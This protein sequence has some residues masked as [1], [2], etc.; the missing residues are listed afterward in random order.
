MIDPRTVVVCGDNETALQ[1][2]ESLRST[3]TGR[4]ILVPT[5]NYGAFEN[6]DIMKRDLGPLTKNQCYLVEN[7]F[8]DRANVDVIKG[9]IKVIDYVGKKVQ[10]MGYKHP[11]FFDKLLVAWG[12][13]RKML[14]MSYSNVFYITDWYSHAKV[15]NN[16]LKAE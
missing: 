3:F 7:D 8:L 4:I 10:I 16:L 12:S 11:L 2:V 6:T 9:Q 5:S 13:H 1:A 14:N 15:H